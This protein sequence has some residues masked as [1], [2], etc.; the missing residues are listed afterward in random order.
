[1]QKFNQE[2]S[3]SSPNYYKRM[4]KYRLR[5]RTESNVASPEPREASWLKEVALAWAPKA[6]WELNWW[7]VWGGDSGHLRRKGHGERDPQPEEHGG[8]QGEISRLWEFWLRVL[9]GHAFA[10]WPWPSGL[11]Y[12]LFTSE[13]WKEQCLLHIKVALPNRNLWNDG[14]VLYLCCPGQWSLANCGHWAC[15]TRPLKWR[16]GIFISFH[17]NLNGHRWPMAG[18]QCSIH[19]TPWWYTGLCTQC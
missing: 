3:K 12:L 4:D 11:A 13:Q 14:N 8:N 16:N 6:A 18:Q 5:G 19:A 9:K 1:M 15:H 2:T 7:K 17:L 10:L